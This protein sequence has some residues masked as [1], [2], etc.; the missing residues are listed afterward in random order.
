MLSSWPATLNAD[1]V[2]LAKALTCTHSY[3]NFV[4]NNNLQYYQNL[5]TFTSFRI[6]LTFLDRSSIPISRQIS[7][8]F[9]RQSAVLLGIGIIFFTARYLYNTFSRRR[10]VH[11]AGG[12][13]RIQDGKQETR[14][15][16]ED[17]EPYKPSVEDVFSVKTM[18]SGSFELPLELVDTIIDHAEYWPHT[19]VIRTG[20]DFTIR[21]G[22]G[23]E[24]Q[25]LVSKTL[26]VVSGRLNVV[27]GLKRTYQIVRFWKK[28]TF[29]WL[30]RPQYRFIGYN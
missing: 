13:D 7:M 30:E 5:D 3:H 26:T 11:A 1:H 23:H 17:F 10:P 29:N 6:I 19:S 8:S 2:H 14:E 20:E 15:N 21:A 24:N 4:H 12:V 22:A 18:L 16:Q 27:E 9:G 28:L 25:F